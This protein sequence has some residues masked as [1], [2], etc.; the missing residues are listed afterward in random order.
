MRR[1]HHARRKR[2]PVNGRPVPF[3]KDVTCEDR[4][5]SKSG[6][7]AV[8]LH[9]HIFKNAGTSVDKI[10]KRN[11]GDRWSTQEFKGPR[12]H[13]KEAIAGFLKHNPNV[14]ALSS[15]TAR[16]PPPDVEGL[17]IIPIVFVRHPIDRLRSAYEFER[18]QN[19]NTLGARLAK[20]HDLKGYLEALL[21]G[22]AN[23]QARNFQTYRLAQ[24]EPGRRPE[25]ERATE[26]LQHLP[27]VG[28]VEAFEHSLTLLV[29]VMRAY[30][31][32][33]RYTNEH[34]NA[35][36]SRDGTLSE[37]LKLVEESLGAVFY[38]RICDCN[39]EDMAIYELLSLQFRG[40]GRSEQ[41]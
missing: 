6:G 11:F 25:L 10:L 26:A 5:Q 19:A 36:Q 8:V 35:S 4:P 18:K 2:D 31:P 22:E 21:N 1:S 41:A 15:H 33:F 24:N 32:D 30:F 3:A 34:E 28:L 7:R 38:K 27:F 40:V 12:R 23:R 16:L 13:N 37:R 17:T 20:Q 14:D 9:Y 39:M 29:S